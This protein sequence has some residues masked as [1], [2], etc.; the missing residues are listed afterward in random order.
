MHLS[1]T[2]RAHACLSQREWLFE[3]RP[4][5]LAMRQTTSAGRLGVA[6]SQNADGHNPERPKRRR[7]SE[8]ATTLTLDNAMAAPAT[9]GLNRPRAAS[10]IAATL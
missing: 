10:G 6:W 5:S 1:A 7:R 3:P 9:I 2:A 4:L 8:L